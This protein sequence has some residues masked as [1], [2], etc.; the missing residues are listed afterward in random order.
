MTNPGWFERLD[1]RLPRASIHQILWGGGGKNGPTPT[2]AAITG[3]RFPAKDESDLSVGIDAQR[4]G[5]IRADIYD[6]RRRRD[7]LGR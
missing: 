2:P 7:P 1:H 4:Y 3:P 5:Y 6:V